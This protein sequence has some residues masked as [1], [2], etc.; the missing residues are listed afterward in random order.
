MALC[1]E[2]GAAIVWVRTAA[3]DRNMP[4]NPIPEPETGNVAVV[5]QIGGQLTKARVITAAEP[6]QP[7]ETAYLVHWATCSK[8]KARKG[9]KTTTKPKVPDVPALF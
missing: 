1:K 7:G 5:R 3:H 4:L 2:C 8:T 9:P 6:L